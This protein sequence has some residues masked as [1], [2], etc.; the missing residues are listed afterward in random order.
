M[1][2]V[3]TDST[4][5]LTPAE[6]EAAGITIVPITVTIDGRDYLEGTELTAEDFY[7]RLAGGV[8]LSTSQPSPG[9]FVETYRRLI[10]A[11]ADEIVSV[12]L[13]ESSSG[14]LNSARV[15]ADMVDV[16]VRLIDSRTTS[17]GLGA[18]ALHLAEHVGDHGSSDVVEVA[19]TMIAGMGTVFILQDLAYV[20]RGG[21]MRRA[22][23]PDGSGDVPVLGGYGGRYEMID[24]GRTI[25]Q[26]VDSMATFLLAGD[27]PRHIAIALAAPDTIEFTEGLEARLRSDDKIVSLHRYRMG[28][29]VAVHTGPGTAGGF[30][31]PA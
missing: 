22:E 6:A 21:R 18:L 30:R 11:G 29:S 16:P 20:L 8:R 27:E 28:P 13:A 23:L 15:A 12:H 25:D 14:T 7:E 26:L 19:E 24:S 3:V 9:R 4:C 31:W 10:D 2:A 17:Y 5:Q 1:I